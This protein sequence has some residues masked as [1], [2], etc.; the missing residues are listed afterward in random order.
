ML[1]FHNNHP[2]WRV[3]SSTGLRLNIRINGIMKKS[4]V[5]VCVCVCVVWVWGW[6]CVCVCGVV[7]VCVCVCMCMCVRVR[8]CVCVC[9]CVC[10]RE[11]E[12]VHVYVCACVWES[13]C[14]CV[15][16]TDE[17]QVMAAHT[18]VLSFGTICQTTNDLVTHTSAGET[19]SQYHR[20]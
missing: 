13:V 2:D 9:V 14:V 18:R 4:N 17:W 10:V 6:V 12:C 11:Y 5:C 19:N 16:F 7:R 15:C 3:W 20:C 8:V 1:S